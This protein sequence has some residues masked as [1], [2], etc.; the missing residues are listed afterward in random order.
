MFEL[1]VA[2]L[3]MHMQVLSKG[4]LSGKEL[5]GPLPGAAK[6]MG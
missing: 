4:H 3:H 1:R 2:A 5:Q 6:M